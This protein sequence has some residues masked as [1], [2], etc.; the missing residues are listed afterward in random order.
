MIKPPIRY[1]G[2][3][4]WLARSLCKEI[5]QSD[6]RLY[7]EPFVGGGAIALN[8]PSYIAKVISDSNTTLMDMWRCLRDA[9]NAL[10]AELGRVEEKYPNTQEAYLDARDE[11]NTTI[12]VR[13]PM[14]IRRAALFLYINARCFNGLWRTNASGL[15]NVPYGKLERPSSI[16]LP[17]AHE[18]SR[19]IR[20]AIIHDGDYWTTLQKIGSTKGATIYADPPY[21]A[22]FGDY[23]KDGFNELDQ[24][25]L[26][27]RLRWCASQGAKVWTTNSDTPLIREVYS[28]AE[29]STMEEWHAVGA[30]G[31]RRGARACLLIRS[32]P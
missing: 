4:S 8:V 27:E 5:E 1:V 12:L 28:W 20:G 2:G 18:I 31:E 22:T 15:F 14:W 30:T 26:A 16:D 7:I 32:R 25:E 19:A 13:R 29:I 21:D 3:K 9:P 23:T 24:R 6:P 11:L 17:E 10:I